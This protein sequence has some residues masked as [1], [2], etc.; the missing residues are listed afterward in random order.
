MD[1]VE[2]V[3]S[4]FENP[5]GDLEKGARAL[6]LIMSADE[7]DKLSLL[8]LGIFMI[9]SN[10]LLVS[11]SDSGPKDSVKH[12]IMQDQIIEASIDFFTPGF[13]KS[14]IHDESLFD[15]FYRS[16]LHA[17]NTLALMVHTSIL[18]RTDVEPADFISDL[19]TDEIRKILSEQLSPTKGREDESSSG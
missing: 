9:V 2:H 17:Q 1:P 8:Y 5:D 7:P 13:L 6:E 18:T 19:A 15:E 4:F 10:N 11:R 14:C 16:C 3:K 12:A